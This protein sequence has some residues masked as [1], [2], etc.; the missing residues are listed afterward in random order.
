[1]SSDGGMRSLTAS[2]CRAAAL[3][4]S[5]VCLFIAPSPIGQAH[6]L[7]ILLRSKC[8]N[9]RAAPGSGVCREARDG[10]C[11][12]HAEG[13]AVDGERRRTQDSRERDSMQG[14]ERVRAPEDT[15]TPSSSA[16]SG[17]CEASSSNV[18]I[19]EN[20]YCSKCSTTDTE[21]PIDGVY[22]TINGDASGCTAQTPPNG[23]CKSCGAGYFL[24]KGGCYKIADPP[25]STI[26]SAAGTAGICQTCKDGYFRNPAN[27]ATSDSCIACS[28]TSIIDGVTGVD[29]CTACSG[30]S[31]AGSQEAPTTTTCSACGP[32][33]QQVSQIVKTAAGV[34]SCVTEEECTEAEGFFIDNTGGKK[35]SACDGTCKTCSGAAGQCTSC[36][37]NTPYLKKD[38][39]SDTG[40]CI[41]AS[42][43]SSDNT[44]YADDTVDP[45]SG[46]L[47][48][49]CA[50]G[51]LKDCA[52]CEKSADDLVCKEC[53]G[54]KFGL[55]KKSCVTE[56]PDNASEKSGVCTCNDGFTPSADSTACVAASSCKTP[57]CQTCTGE[58]QENETC[59]ACATGYYLT[60]TGQCVGSCDKLGSYYA[61]NNVCKPCNPSC[62]SCVGVNA[63]Q[64]SA[65]PAGKAL[66]YTS[67]TK[68]DQG[69]SCVDECKV[70][71]GGCIDCGAVIGGSK[72][73]SRCGDASQA[74]LNGDC[75]A[76]TT[77]RTK[78]CTQ[79]DGGACT[80]CASGLQ[81]A[82]YWPP[83]VPGSEWHGCTVCAAECARLAAGLRGDGGQ[84]LFLLPWLTKR[85][86]VCGQHTDGHCSEGRRHRG[87]GQPA[88]LR[89]SR[90]PERRRS[91]TSRILEVLSWS[92]R[93]VPVRSCSSRWRAAHVMPSTAL[94]CAV[95]E[96]RGGT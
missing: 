31:S 57:H 8:Y 90:R 74:P 10:A 83:C 47:C 28:D 38:T 79:I 87:T 51:G 24:H 55:N 3:A 7:C 18:L 84:L 62:A 39:G 49:K 29:G 19:G 69:G 34:T 26:C 1:M 56:C 4:P 88:S 72:Y 23:T 42:V 54:K 33:A 17:Q 81:R 44:H 41:D 13:H 66:K 2:T 53:T 37:T 12:G 77:M 30:P 82:V 20:T 67:E 61:D 52:T 9:T 64:C 80:Q 60:P 43:C 6:G 25:G 22:K 96:D 11:V 48:R 76:N 94:R 27:A 15:C 73:C 71:T 5:C 35:C 70:N 36:K 50:E 21:A 59:T 86:P 75:A 92:R 40:T 46:K 89:K 68:V 16:T 63:N 93:C 65:C 78:F 58:S 95:S 14:M 91:N 45:T 32:D 85:W